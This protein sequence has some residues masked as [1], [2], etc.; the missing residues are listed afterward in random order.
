MAARGIA[1]SPAAPVLPP[2]GGEM[3]DSA[4]IA[5][6]NTGRLTVID[7]NTWDLVEP[8]TAH[9][10]SVLDVAVNPTGTLIASAGE[11]AYVRGLC[12]GPRS[13]CSTPKPSRS[14]R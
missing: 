3:N 9:Q 5:A 11:D 4:L 8:I 2:K 7:T 12:F 1:P 14:R 6:D 10:G 13:A